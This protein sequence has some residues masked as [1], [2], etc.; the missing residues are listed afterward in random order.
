MLIVGIHASRI[1]IAIPVDVVRVKSGVNR[2]F[3]PACV[4]VRITI[5]KL[6]FIPKQVVYGVVGVP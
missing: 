6:Y 2:V 4:P 5:N 3:D 1:S